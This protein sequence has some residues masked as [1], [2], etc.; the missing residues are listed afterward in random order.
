MSVIDMHI[1]MIALEGD[2]RICPD[3][4]QFV[5]WDDVQEK[6]LMG[7]EPFVPDRRF[8]HLVWL[9]PVSERV[10]KNG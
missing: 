7:H 10:P 5:V 8:T 4:R 1:P 9:H 3:G 2:E 6:W